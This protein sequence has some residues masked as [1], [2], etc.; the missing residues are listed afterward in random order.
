[1]T[2]SSPFSE[3][4]LTIGEAAKSVAM[5]VE[6]EDGFL[7]W[8]PSGRLN[9]ES[10]CDPAGSLDRFTRASTYPY[11]DL[12]TCIRVLLGMYLSPPK[13][14]GD[15]VILRVNAPGRVDESR[16]PSTQ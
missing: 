5:V 14:R 10:L 6:V 9:L 12:S 16:Y 4:L 11:D 8:E 7:V 1:M 15:N 2:F 3:T 13:K